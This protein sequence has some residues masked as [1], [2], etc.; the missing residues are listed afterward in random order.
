MIKNKSGPGTENIKKNMQK[1]LKK[2]QTT[3]EDA[4][5]LQDIHKIQTIPKEI[6]TCTKKITL[7]SNE[8]IFH[9]LKEI[10]LKVL[11]KSGYLQTLKYRHVN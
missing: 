10:Y 3:H 7:S 5:H 6:Y 4:N 9:E 11:E 1:Y 8:I 2:T